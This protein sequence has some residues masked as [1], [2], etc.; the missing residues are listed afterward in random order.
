MRSRS[1]RYRRSPAWRHR[2]PQC[3]RPRG[4]EPIPSTSIRFKQ[5]TVSDTFGQGCTLEA[6]V[7]QVQRLLQDGMS[8]KDV[9]YALPEVRI[10]LEGCDIKGLDIRRALPMG[11]TT[12]CAVGCSRLHRRGDSCHRCVGG[13]SL[14]PSH[15][16]AHPHRNGRL[17]TRSITQTPQAA[18]RI[19]IGAVSQQL[20]AIQSAAIP[21]P[22][23]EHVGL[24]GLP[25]ERKATLESFVPRVRVF[26]RRQR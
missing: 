6:M 20:L 8:D 16:V 25:I 15:Y 11:R 13:W 10:V 21:D 23:L 24:V 2:S 9:C 12:T 17:A 14:D 22:S 4:Q 5:A 19:L 7:V 18:S 1:P 3:H 26:P